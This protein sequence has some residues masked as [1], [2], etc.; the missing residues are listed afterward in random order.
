MQLSNYAALSQKPAHHVSYLREPALDSGDAGSESRTNKGYREESDPGKSQASSKARLSCKRRPF[1]NQWM[2]E[3]A[4]CELIVDS[5]VAAA[6]VA[7][8]PDPARVG[9]R[10][11]RLV[12]RGTTAAPSF[13][14][15]LVA[16]R[17]MTTP[18]AGRA[19]DQAG[20]TSRKPR[21]PF[22]G[23]IHRRCA[24][25]CVNEYTLAQD[26]QVEP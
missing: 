1:L 22:R 21:S 26:V 6:A 3:D 8:R 19:R 24:A 12:V 13:K 5:V 15:L 25:L 23:C 18:N 10:V 9:T 14:I 20:R 7:E 2:D 16:P 4:L 11:S 17:P